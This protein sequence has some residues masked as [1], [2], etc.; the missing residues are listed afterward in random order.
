MQAL[1]TTCV[2]VKASMHCT[3][4]RVICT[5][6]TLSSTRRFDQLLV[7]TN[8]QLAANLLRRHFRFDS[9]S[10]SCAAHKHCHASPIVRTA[11]RRASD[12]S[13]TNSTL[14][15]HSQIELVIRIDTIS[16]DLTQHK[17]MCE[18]LCDCISALIKLA[19][20]DLNTHIASV[21]SLLVYTI[22]AM[23]VIFSHSRPFRSTCL[24]CTKRTSCRA[25][26]PAAAY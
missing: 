9:T 5:S 13:P 23:L 8:Q 17:G 25:R 7:R 4:G 26:P 2:S 22:C 21:G 15:A 19:Q 6:A 14:K 18:V 10:L 1:C 12:I 16:G 24:D 11:E 3:A 20:A